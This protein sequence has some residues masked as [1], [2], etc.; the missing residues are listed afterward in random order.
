MKG[1]MVAGKKKKR[2]G[3]RGVRK[4][5]KQVRTVLML[6]RPNRT[7]S[8]MY[9]QQEGCTAIHASLALVEKASSFWSIL[10]L[11]STKNYG[12]FP[13]EKLKYTCSFR[14]LSGQYRRQVGGFP[15][16]PLSVRTYA[17]TPYS[18]RNKH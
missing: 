4:G 13:W 7:N 1:D 12:S 14:G 15:S 6:W 9:V 11:V 5:K 16:R 17:C 3:K 18:P 8:R 10:V 2:R